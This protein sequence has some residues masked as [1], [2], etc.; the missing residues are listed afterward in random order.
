MR[1]TFVHPAGC[2]S[3]PGGSDFTVL[4]NRMVPIGILQ[5]AA[6]LD[7]HGHSTCVYD[8][9]GPNASPH[10]AENIEKVLAT[11]PELIA[12]SATTSSFLDAYDMAVLLKHRRPEV[13]I[14]FGGAHASAVGAALL[15]HFPSIDYLCIGEG[16]GLMEDLAAGRPLQDIGNLAF[17]DSDR[18]ISNPR[19]RRI[20]QLDDLPFPAYEKLPGFPREYHL[21]LFSFVKRYGATMI[22]SR[23]CTYACSYCDRTV[24]GR[25]YSYNSPAYVHEHMRHLRDQYG[26]RHVDFYDDLFTANRRRVLELCGLLTRQPLGMNFNCAIR[27]GQMDEEVLASLK[28]AGCFQ[29]S[30]GIESAAPELL[31]RHK[32][33]VTVESVRDTVERVRAASLRVKGLFIFGLPGES[34]QT[35]QLTSDFIESMPFDEINISKFSPFH[36]APLRE[37]CVS[38]CDG[39]F[40]DDWRLLNCLNFTY[41]PKAFD[42]RQQM[43]FS[44]NQCIDRFYRGRHYQELFLK[45]LWQHRWSFCHVLRHLVPFLRAWLQF[46]PNEKQLGASNEWP[47][48]HPSQPQA[49]FHPT[50]FRGSAL[51]D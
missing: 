32:S 43:D 19:R 21:P 10:L 49:L 40:H 2:N 35:V 15:R 41:V 46:K 26:V 39:T 34:P 20:V 12:F 17:R 16:E 42:S 13:R 31:A 44:Y 47:V 28:R 27:V 29:V 7:R 37:E 36:G 4:V 30:I 23:G 3:V 33:G 5:M 51:F 50:T 45:R 9:L 1:V 25:Q 18:V 11:D 22:T 6:V 48:L 38:G 24:F 14:V 8:C